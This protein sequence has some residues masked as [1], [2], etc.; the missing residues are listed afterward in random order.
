MLKRH[1]N[2][3]GTPERKLNFLTIRRLLSQTKNIRKN[4]H[5]TDINWVNKRPLKKQLD[6]LGTQDYIT[7]IGHATYLM[8]FSGKIILIDPFFSNI[9]GP[10]GKFGP[11]RYVPPALELD[12]LPQ[13]DYILITHNHYDHLDMPFLKKLNSKSHTTI[14]VPTDLGKLIKKAG[15][16][17]IIELAWF[18]TTNAGP[19]SFTAVPAYHYSKRGLFD[20]NVSHW[21]G[22]IL[23]TEKHTL[24]HSGD[25]AYGPIFKDI[26]KK[27]GP[28][29][30]AMLGIGAYMPVDMMKLVHTDP[31]EALQI[32][33]DLN[34]RCILPMHWGTIVLTTEPI[35]EPLQKLY[36]AIEKNKSDMNVQ[37]KH[38]GD[39][40]SL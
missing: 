1:K 36:A 5:Q 32:A 24:F 38:I 39:V 9:A 4:L 8:Q 34:A 33:L 40:L 22:F 13:I 2:L 35:D 16:K 11:K 23:S 3:P 31:D 18:E 19:L 10:F 30:F 29:D 7:W 25:T 20:R 26:G 14:I 6:A 28:F 17:H 27:Y 15:F 12:E 21:C 37:L